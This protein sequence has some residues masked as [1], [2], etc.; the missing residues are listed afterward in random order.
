VVRVEQVCIDCQVNNA[1]RLLP[2]LK[3]NGIGENG[4]RNKIMQAAEK[5]LDSDVPLYLA[6]DVFGCLLE[7]TNISAFFGS[8]KKFTNEQVINF[9]EK[10]RNNCKD[11]LLER[12]RHSILGNLID[13]G[14]PGHVEK[15][16][17]KELE[18][19]HLYSFGVNHFED[20]KQDLSQAK[21]LVYLADNCG[22]IIFDIEVI[23]FLRKYYPELDI[24]LVV[25]S[26]EILN[27]MTLEDMKQINY[28]GKI[29][30]TGTGLPGVTLSEANEDFQK[31]MDNADVIISKG[32]GNFEGLYD[33][34]PHRIYFI[35]VVK[36]DYIADMLGV[37]KG[38]MMLLLNKRHQSI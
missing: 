14:I 19:I 13:Y 26:K 24:T 37:Q 22:E 18:N 28:T 11:D 10:N 15:D 29:V 23:D 3:V 27:D 30:G 35:F 6:K 12:I 5:H 4:L 2:K 21:K 34:A 32:Q 33:A 1:F 38:D 17:E 8:L 20:L 9:L 36:C 7:H 16:I 25:R 31:L